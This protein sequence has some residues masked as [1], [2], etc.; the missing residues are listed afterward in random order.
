MLT[1][2]LRTVRLDAIDGRSQAGVFLRRFREE[3]TAQ[4]GGDLTP[5]QIILV[6]EAAKSA[7][8]VKAIGEYIIQQDSLVCD[9]ELLPIV[10]QREQLVT[11]LTRLLTTLGLERKAKPVPDLTAYIASKARPAEPSPR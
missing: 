5:A 6:E 10:R 3:S 7:L 8:I 4:L 2:V 11:A 9:G 1:R